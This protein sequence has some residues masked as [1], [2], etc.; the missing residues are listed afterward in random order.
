M[1]T[2]EVRDPRI[3]M[4][5]ITGVVVTADL[6]Y[7]SISVQVS[8]E[9]EERAR[10]LE[11]LQS[12]AGFLRK[13]VSRAL[14]TRIVPDLRFQLDEGEAHRARIEAVLSDLRQE[15]DL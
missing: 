4:V 7:A 13:R 12:A 10:A 2:H 15:G 3:G 14:A 6:G 5:T 9:Q 8:G 1:L 11:G